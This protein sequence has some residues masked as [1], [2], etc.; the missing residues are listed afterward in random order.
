MGSSD[1][2]WWSGLWPRSWELLDLR[3]A[4]GRLWEYAAGSDS[5]AKSATET[6]IRC[7]W[8]PP[9]S[10]L[11]SRVR[12]AHRLPRMMAPSRRSFVRTI[13]VRLSAWDTTFGRMRLFQSGNTL[14]GTY[15]FGSG[16][17]IEGSLSENGRRFDFVYVEPG[18]VRG[19]GWFILSG[20][21]FE[22]RWRQSGTEQWHPWTGT[23][24]EGRSDRRPAA[25]PADVPETATPHIHVDEVSGIEWASWSLSFEHD[26]SLPYLTTVRFYVRSLPDSPPD[27]L[28]IAIDVVS[29]I[30]FGSQDVLGTR[31]APVPDWR[32][33]NEPG[34]GF[35]LTP[36]V[37]WYN[38]ESGLRLTR[39]IYSNDDLSRRPYWPTSR[40]WSHD[41]RYLQHPLWQAARAER[42]DV[43]FRPCAGIVL[44]DDR[45]EAVAGLM[46]AADGFIRQR[47]L[48]VGP[49]K[50]SEE[51]LARER[52]AQQERL[53]A[54]RDLMERRRVELQ[55]IASRYATELALRR[56]EAGFDADPFGPAPSDPLNRGKWENSRRNIES[57]ELN[58]R[59][60]RY[61]FEE[62][63]EV[64]MELRA[65]RRNDPGRLA[66][67]RSIAS[68]YA[69]TRPYQ[70]DRIP[71]PFGP[72]PLRAW[73]S[74]SW[75]AERQ[76][77]LADLEGVGTF[78]EL[79]AIVMELR[80]Q[81]R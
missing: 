5:T 35:P 47:R 75:R 2:T 23:L 62:L 33:G 26:G 71:D 50:P 13:R 9:Y 25:Q 78:E 28:E 45:W 68:R 67:L 81:P 32:V 22:G 21:S 19:E 42:S 12:R 77:I 64:V 61:S 65:Q 46:R 15:A 29:D 38:L 40:D 72:D 24:I 8:L 7:L 10:R 27:V 56:Y 73:V 57:I 48:Q 66:R 41:D 34:T 16:A 63:R 55:N 20:D 52:L 49:Y 60:G 31:R 6:T 69:D 51:D 76:R 3:A 43:L 54:Q 17:T 11:T 74:E 80:A 18:D 4:Y 39:I 1:G 14:H 59:Q 58:G 79:T 70:D 44:R 30:F 36:S 53:Q 37:Q